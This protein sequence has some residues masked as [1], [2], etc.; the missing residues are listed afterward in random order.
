MKCEY[1]GAEIQAGSEVIWEG[2][3]FCNPLH[4]KWWKDSGPEIKDPQ[5]KPPVVSAKSN[6]TAW[7]IGLIAAGVFVVVGTVVGIRVAGIFFG[8][9]DLVDAGLM[10]IASEQNKN[11][12]EMIDRVTR[13]DNTIAV[14]G[15]TLIYNYTLFNNSGAVIDT[16]RIIESLKPRIINNVKTNDEM[17]FFR[18]NEVTLV[19]KYSDSTGVPLMEIRVTPDD[20]R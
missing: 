4:R 19:Y 15:N 1:C 17:K 20:Y 9:T 2:H 10:H 8:G 13:L 12:P 16:S 7:I 11:L 6:R 3:R 5:L 14:P 18:D